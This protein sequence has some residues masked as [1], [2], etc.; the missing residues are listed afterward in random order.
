MVLKWG[1]GIRER[2]LLERACGL[3]EGGV[4]GVWV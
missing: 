3:L 4:D 1:F 2:S